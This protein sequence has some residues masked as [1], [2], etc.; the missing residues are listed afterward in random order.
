[1][2]IDTNNL[3]QGLELLRLNG[4]IETKTCVIKIDKNIL[5]CYLTNNYK[6]FLAGL[7]I[8]LSNDNKEVKELGISD[9][10]KLINYINLFKEADIDIDI[11]TNK[12]YLKSPTLIMTYLL[13]NKEYIKNEVE[14][15]KFDSLYE[16]AKGNEFL[17]TPE[18]IKSL[19]KYNKILNNSK[20]TLCCDSNVKKSIHL[21]IENA[22]NEELLTDFEINKT[23]NTFTVKLPQMFMN[24]LANMPADK[25]II[26]SI[27]DKTPILLKY[28][29]KDIIT[30]YL[31]SPVQTV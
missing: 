24:V 9:I 17:L 1:M 7:Q 15:D 5:S 25:D 19:L 6:T 14:K 16:I 23:I 29:T 26:C 3:I 18:I 27:N 20:L 22:V 13:G 21:R 8:N 12:L 10:T 11:I 31:M 4:D 28:E 30:T 2:K